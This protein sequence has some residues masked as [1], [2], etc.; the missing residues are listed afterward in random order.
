MSGDF[1][2]GAENAGPENAG[3]ENA[4]PSRNAAS[5]CCIC[6]A[7][8][9]VTSSKGIGIILSWFFNEYAAVKDTCA[10]GRLTCISLQCLN[11]TLASP[12]FT[13]SLNFQA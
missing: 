6:M 3:P 12:Q 9:T 4:G 5:L 2:G 13:N 11:K 10:C 1:I 7:K 8:W